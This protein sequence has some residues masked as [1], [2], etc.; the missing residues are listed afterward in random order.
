MSCT[1]GK[2]LPKKC[3]SNHLEPHSTFPSVLPYQGGV[4]TNGRLTAIP[5]R[6]LVSTILSSDP[7]RKKAQ[8]AM[9]IGGVLQYFFA[10]V[11]VIGVSDKLPTQHYPNI[12]LKREGVPEIMGTKP[13]KALMGSGASNRGSKR[14]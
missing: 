12:N 1:I 5:V 13:L 9:Q 14:F 11:V 2:L 6:G 8:M 4:N 10:E 7:N 3:A